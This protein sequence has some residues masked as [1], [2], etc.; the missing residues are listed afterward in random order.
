VSAISIAH[1]GLEQGQALADC[2]DGELAATIGA[3]PSRD[4]RRLV[5][6]S[7]S[8]VIVEFGEVLGDLLAVAQIRAAMIEIELNGAGQRQARLF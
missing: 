4:F 2:A 5:E 8:D 3:I 1:G 7:G 6:T